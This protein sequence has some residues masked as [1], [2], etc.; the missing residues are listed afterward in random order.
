MRCLDRALCSLFGVCVS[1]P[2]PKSTSNRR[3]SKKGKM[4]LRSLQPNLQFLIPLLQRSDLL[5]KSLAFASLF[6]V[7]GEEEGDFLVEGAEVG[8]GLVGVDVGGHFALLLC[9][10]RNLVRSFDE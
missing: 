4:R 2:V 1:L 8:V 5:F 7:F 3:D 9:V 6:F 10:E